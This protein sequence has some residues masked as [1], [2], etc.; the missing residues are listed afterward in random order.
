MIKLYGYKK[1]STVAK[2]KVLME[3]LNISYEYIDNVE[4]KL[5]ADEIK[6]IHLKSELDIKKIFN[7]S[8]NKYKELK[9]K[10]KLENMS[11][12]EKYELLSSDGMLVKRPLLEL[13]DKVLVGFKEGI[14]TLEI[15]KN[16]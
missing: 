6:K 11:D 2:A 16:N 13:E 8:G 9:L 15:E 7:T 12:E 14:W 3:N 5:S 10:D 4:N 1:C